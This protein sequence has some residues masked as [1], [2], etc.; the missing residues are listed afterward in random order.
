MLAFGYDAQRTSSLRRCVEL[1]LDGVFSNYVDRMT[2]V[3]PRT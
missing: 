1:G 2:S 3:L